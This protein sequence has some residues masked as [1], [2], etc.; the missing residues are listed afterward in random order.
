MPGAS[1]TLRQAFDSMLESKRRNNLRQCYLT[2]LRIYLTAFIR[3][4]EERLISTMTVDD[5]EKWFSERGEKP[6]TRTSNAGRIGA[7]FAHAYRRGWITDNPIRRLEKVRIDR[8]P[9]AILTVEQAETL[10]RFTAKKKPRFI[11]YVNAGAF[12]WCPAG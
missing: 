5:V 8:K 4:R 3:G 9:P 6:V 7:L 10:L 2:S 11:A 1:V 12:G